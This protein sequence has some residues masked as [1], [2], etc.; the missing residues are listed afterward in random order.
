MASDSPHQ[1]SYT[2]DRLGEL[3]QYRMA[4]ATNGK[5]ADD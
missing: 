5:C 3:Q 2:L 4:Q 1:H